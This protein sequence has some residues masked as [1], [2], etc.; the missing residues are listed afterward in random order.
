M[1]YFAW[2]CF[3]FFCCPATEPSPGTEFIIL[4]LQPPSVATGK[5]RGATDRGRCP[6]PLIKIFL[7]FRIRKSGYILPVPP[8]PRGA[9]R[10]RHGR[11]GG[12]RWTLWRFKDELRQRGRRSRVV[13]TPRRWRQVPEKQTFSGATVAKEPGRRG[14]LGVSRKPLRGEMSDRLRCPVCSCAFFALVARETADAA[15][16]RH[17]PHP[18]LSRGERSLAK[19]GRNRGAGMRS[20]IMTSLPATNAKRLRKGAAATTQSILPFRAMDCFADARNDA[21]L[22]AAANH[23]REPLA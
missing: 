4:Q 3:R 16:I 10:D 15:R 8:L 11:G 6:A 14:E 18:L 9:F 22:P 12:M 1:D 2:G 13:L 20:R 7:F 17:S 19:P 23:D 21:L 5:S